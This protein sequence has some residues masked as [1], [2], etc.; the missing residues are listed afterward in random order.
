MSL[1]AS[2]GRLASSCRGEVAGVEAGG[3]EQVAEHAGAGLAG[4]VGSP[5]GVVDEAEGAGVRG[6]AAVGVVDAEVEAELGARGEHAVG[7]VGAL[8]DEVV[9]ED[10]DVGL[11]AVEREGAASPRTLRGRR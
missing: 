2:P 9:D 5:G 10:A 7:L 1:E 11:G 4:L 6:E 3:L 8:G